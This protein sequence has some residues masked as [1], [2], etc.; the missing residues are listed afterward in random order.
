MPEGHQ[1]YF[2]QR[3]WD[4]DYFLEQ[5]RKTGP[6]THEYIKNVLQGKHFT[7]QTYNGCLGILRLTRAYGPDRLEAACKRAIK[8]QSYSYRT[9]HNI[10]QNNLDKLEPTD[11]PSLFT[12]PEHDNLRGPQAYN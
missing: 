3:G 2:E 8:G 11:Q 7:E 4:G 9:L 5:A 10:L 1:R 12:M 6:Y